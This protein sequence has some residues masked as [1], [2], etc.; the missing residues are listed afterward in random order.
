MREKKRP[1]NYELL[2]SYESPD[3]LYLLLSQADRRQA[4]SH[5][6]WKLD[7]MVSARNAGQAAH[8]GLK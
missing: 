6:Y 3:Q 5:S 2:M 8:P 4:D 1:D 7:F